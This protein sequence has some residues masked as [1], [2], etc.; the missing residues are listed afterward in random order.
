MKK[1]MI[2]SALAAAAAVCGSAQVNSPV[3][4]GRLERGIRMYEDRNYIGCIDQLRGI[5]R[6]DLSA[7]QRE[8][9]DWIMAQ[10]AYRSEGPQAALPHFRMFLANYPYSLLRQQAL[11]RIGDCLFSAGEYDKALRAY[12]HVSPDA[13]TADLAEKLVYRMAYS[14]LQLSNLDRARAGFEKLTGVCAFSNAARFYLGY[15]DYAEGNYSAALRN[16]T[17]VNTA[18]APGDK[19]DYYLAQI[20]FVQNDFDKALARARAVLRRDA[21]ASSEHASEARRI[22]GE[23][24]WRLGQES[25]AVG[26]LRQ[27]IA[28]CDEPRSSALYITGLYDYERGDYDAA[29]RALEQI[30]ARGADDAMTQSAYLYVGQALHNEGNDDAAIL[31]F[32][33]ALRMEADLDVQEAAYY[34]YAVL[35]FAGAN[36]PFGSSVDTFEEFLRRYPSGRYSAEVQEYLAEGYLADKDYAKAVERIGRMTAP[37][38]RVLAVRQQA[39]Y[40]LGA[41]ELSSGDHAA[42]VTHLAD[43]ASM[44][45]QNPAV[46]DESLLLLGE[47]YLAQGNCG[48]AAQALD[49]YLKN[50]STQNPNRPLALFDLGYAEFG[51][52]NYSAAATAFRGALD[53]VPAL[54]VA[55]QADIL[56]RLADIAYY[57]SDIESAEDLYDEAYARF[58]SAG[59]Y[60]LF[61]RSLMAGYRNDYDGKIDGLTRFA[62]EFPTSSLMPDALLEKTEAY[63]RQNRQ[64]D[65]ID[66]YRRLVAEYPGTS[67]GRQGY[68]QMALTLVNMG[69]RDE[70]VRAYKDVISLYPSSEEAARAATL[71]KHVYASDGKVDEYVEFISSVE[72]APEIDN[73]EVE[74]LK[75]ESAETAYDNSGDISRFREF[76]AEY[77]SGAY[78]ASALEILMDDALAGGRRDEAAQYAAAIVERFPDSAAAESALE[79]KADSEY[80]LGQGEEALATWR[81]LE[82]KAST[83][84]RKE[85][86]RMGIIR[87]ARDLADD[88]L[89]LATTEAVLSSSA[90]GST[91]RNEA[92]FSRALALANTGAPDEAR[93]LWRSVSTETDDVYGAKS[94]Y[95]LAENLFGEGRNDDAMK[96]ASALVE[97]GTPHRYWLARGFILISDIYAAQGKD[98]EARE[99]LEALREN[100]PEK[101]SDIFLMIDSRLN[102]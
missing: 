96:V 24:L 46:A 19:A 48:S 25:E 77:P 69:R 22:A 86:A 88:P 85:T 89:V 28:G 95:Y 23:S 81:R 62:Q 64:D 13:L 37:G 31:A 92:V 60:P 51:A 30:T 40:M 6:E 100:Y 71:L 75:F 55:N 53:A 93:T 20:Y 78:T 98:F 84:R 41:Q 44:R 66:V 35:R 82:E 73:A 27:Y 67:Q 74:A 47:A 52:K 1:A 87:V 97:S 65:A 90:A 16:L 59:D 70:G 33:K 15:I 18:V 76:V 102:K 58:P 83:P 10:C 94:A 9:V 7:D 36:V 11:M 72:D 63:L 32:D 50:T 38:P 3:A 5:G 61:Q 21:Q 8:R 42:A 56:S 80:R 43:A 34:N 49:S 14:E 26:M 39:L 91:A 79:V 101:D 12:S 29:V 68:L 2:I 4:D 54:P 17:A 45:A 57:S 99:Y